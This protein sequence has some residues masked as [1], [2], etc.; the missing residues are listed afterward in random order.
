MDDRLTALGGYDDVFLRRELI[1][2]GYDDRTIAHM[3]RSGSWHRV[4]HGAYIDQGRWAEL[5][6]LGRHGAT[7]RAVVRQANSDVVLSHVSALPAVEAPIWGLDLSMVHVT[8]RDRR[9][10]RREAGVNQHVGTLL[11]EDVVNAGGLEVTSATRTA[12]DITSV[13]TVEAAL[14]VVDY[15]LHRRLT[16]RRQLRARYASMT[17]W[18]NTLRTDLVLRLADGRSESV[19]ETR[20]REL[21]RRQGLPAPTPQHPIRDHDGRI[22]AY[23]DLAWPEHGV[24]LE[25]DGRVKYEAL[26]R[27]GE[28]PTDVVL[29]EKRREEMI[30]ELTGWRCIRITW[31]DLAYPERTAMRIRRLLFPV[32]TAA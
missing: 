7:C 30:C 14:V 16:T 23:V 13:T 9:G 21:C 26:L 1:A 24:F 15:L 4:R 29:R 19:G 27:E 2:D 18:P 28:S 5:D 32:R 12:L 25:F 31:A 11:A 8:R 10:G 6:D 3:V 22:V 20:S 17:H